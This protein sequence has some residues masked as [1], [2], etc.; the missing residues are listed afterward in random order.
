MGQLQIFVIELVLL[1]FSSMPSILLFQDAPNHIFCL[2]KSKTGIRKL[3][4][5]YSF[6]QRMKL[7]HIAEHISECNYH[8]ATLKRLLTLRK[9]YLLLE[10]S[11]IVVLF[12]YAFRLIPEHT[13][14][15]LLLAKFFLVELPCCLF[16]FIM[17]KHGSNGGV[18]W[19]WDIEK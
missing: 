3:T 10:A 1:I 2:G 12:L 17:T 13:G 9:V 5:R 18:V 19:R 11:S 8:A 15:L 4:S 6:W 14:R 7:L 16:F